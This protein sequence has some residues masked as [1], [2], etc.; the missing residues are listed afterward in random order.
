MGLKASSIRSG[1]VERTIVDAHGHAID[2]LRRKSNVTWF[3]IRKDEP[4]SNTPLNDEIAGA[5]ASFFFGGSG[6][7]HGALTQ[8]FTSAG[9][10]QHDPYD[11]G[12]GYT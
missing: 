8:A 5:L 2:R 12:P 10:I 7:S 4:M 1:R 3:A 9:V 6:P 11:V